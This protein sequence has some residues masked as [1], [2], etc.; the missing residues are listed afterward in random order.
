MFMKALRG[1]DFIIYLKRRLC[2][3]LTFILPSHRHNRAW[4]DSPHHIG[5]WLDSPRFL[6]PIKT[7][8]SSTLRRE[9]FHLTLLIKPEREKLK[10]EI[11]LRNLDVGMT[12]LVE[13]LIL[14]QFREILV[15]SRF[16]EIL[17]LSRF[18]SRRYYALET[19]RDMTRESWCLFGIRNTRQDKA[20]SSH[21][22]FFDKR[23]ERI[24]LVSPLGMSKG[25]LWFMILNRVKSEIVKNVTRIFDHPIVNS[26]F[27]HISLSWNLHYLPA[28][29]DAALEGREDFFFHC[30]QCL[31]KSSKY[32]FSKWWHYVR[33][34]RED[35]ISVL[36]SYFCLLDMLLIIL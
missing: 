24:S 18:L 32:L 10:N 22:F 3:F 17:V 2:V 15:L 34:G 30:S 29:E 5:A 8:F 21:L 33:T 31:K 19:R 9:N 16:W 1:R 7:F 35:V 23:R 12:I 6:P 14:S 20:V 25:S 11:S 26:N 28:V 27:N 13:K 36:S 4:L